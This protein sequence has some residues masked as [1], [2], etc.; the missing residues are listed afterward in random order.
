MSR[1][2]P[3]SPLRVVMALDGEGVCPGSF[4][5][6]D[7]CLFPAVQQEALERVVRGAGLRRID[8]DRHDVLQVRRQ[9]QRRVAEVMMVPGLAGQEHRRVKHRHHRAGLPTAAADAQLTELLLDEARGLRQGRLADVRLGA[10]VRAVDRSAQRLG[11]GISPLGTP[12]F[13]VNLS[14]IRLSYSGPYQHH[15]IEK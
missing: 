11:H 5:C 12:K 7:E 8:A 13:N 3:G 10:N 6:Q 14:G 1:R 9:L 4:E 15:N 2:A